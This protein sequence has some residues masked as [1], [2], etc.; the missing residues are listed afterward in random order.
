MFDGKFIA[1]L[2]AIAVSIFAI[3][4]FNTKK[5]TSHEGFGFGNLPSTT[6]RIERVCAHNKQEA[7]KGNF[8]SVSTNY[9]IGHQGG[10][11]TTQPNFQANI[12]PRF[13]N[14]GAKIRYN[15]ANKEHQASSC[16]PLTFGGMAR[17]NFTKESFHADKVVESNYASGNYNE[18]S[19]QSDEYQDASS[20]VPVGDMTNFN[21]LGE[22]HHTICYDRHIHSTG[23]SR[24]SR[25]GC[26][27][28]GDIPIVPLS[29]NW[30]TPAANPSLDLRQGALQV[31]G[32]IGN[33]TSLA[34][35]ELINST[36]GRTT[37]GGVD[38]SS[39]KNM[40]TGRNMDTVQVTA[41]V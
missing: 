9:Q 20:M 6:H 17:E 34:L 21:E 1:T 24:H 8:Q 31:M 39:H 25:H 22:H 28:R 12:S 38:M 11:Y 19:G 41:F 35:A 5:I 7:D 26:P 10:G 36:S 14:H 33:G 30:F 16:D 37:I 4:N 29:G 27:L 3:C 15:D 13:S 40:F 32:G 18:I 23:K 2:F